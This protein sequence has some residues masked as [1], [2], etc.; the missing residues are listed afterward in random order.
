MVNPVL[1]AVAGAAG[2]LLLARK[3]APS[4]EEVKALSDHWLATVCKHDPAEVVRL[5]AP[6]GV[7]VGTVAQRIKQGRADI[8]TYFDMF[9]AKPG[10]CGEYQSHLVQSYPG[11]AV[12][13]GTYT[14]QWL[15]GGS[16]KVVPARFTFVYRH[17]PDGWK[18]ANHHSS[19]L[20]D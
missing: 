4:P 20:P 5:Y 12:D 13:S 16:P 14:F 7:L 8:K 6:D 11:W 9:L 1:A 15:E 10:L 2:G 19:A 17:T 18:I 3:P